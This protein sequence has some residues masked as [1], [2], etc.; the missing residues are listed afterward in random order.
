MKTSILLLTLL[1]SSFTLAQEAG[2]REEKTI[3]IKA[4]IAKM[5]MTP[6]KVYRL[7]LVELAAA[8]FAEEKFAPC[9][10]KAMKENKKATMKVAAY[11][12]S[13]LDCKVD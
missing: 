2:K 7:E 5:L 9:L 3:E 4:H 13:V 12:L 8:Y 11:S 6:K 1:M 10:Q